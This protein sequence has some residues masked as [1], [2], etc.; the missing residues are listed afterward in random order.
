MFQA[1]FPCKNAAKCSQTLFFQFG[2]IA[3][4]MVWGSPKGLQK[5]KKAGFSMIL[6]CFGTFLDPFR[7][8]KCLNM[9]LQNSFWAL[10]W[11][12]IVQNRSKISLGPP[13]GLQEA[14]KAGF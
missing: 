13:K 6:K 5:A 8:R 4:H 3:K 9:S 2:K 7:G 10:I 14:Q 12:K 1:H 11:A